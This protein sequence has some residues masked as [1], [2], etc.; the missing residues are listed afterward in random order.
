MLVGR[1]GHHGFMVKEQS[2]LTQRE[3]CQISKIETMICRGMSR[4]TPKSWSAGVKI[5]LGDEQYLQ[6][7]DVL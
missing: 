1:G 7:N 4:V 5:W 3:G 2:S 6:L